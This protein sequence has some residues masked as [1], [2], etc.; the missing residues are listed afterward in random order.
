MLE[1]IVNGEG[2]SWSISHHRSLALQGS[3]LGI[4]V[5]AKILSGKFMQIQGTYRQ[6]LVK[7]TVIAQQSKPIN[8]E[9]CY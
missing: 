5:E 2:V 1:I 3:E 7:M 4:P 6:S 9:L 8:S